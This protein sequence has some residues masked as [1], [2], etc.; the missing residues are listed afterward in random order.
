MPRQIS[1]SRR[2]TKNHTCPRPQ[3]TDRPA[4]RRQRRR[5]RPRE[6]GRRGC[7]ARSLD[8]DTDRV[9][10]SS[11]HHTKMCS[12]LVRAPGR[13]SCS[14]AAFSERARYST[15]DKRLGFGFA[16]RAGTRSSSRDASV[17]D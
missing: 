11:L 16:C 5:Q 17:C 15:V 2:R 7:G 10:W 8:A 1:T 12:M 14:W 4:R 6:A 13:S 9:H 3:A